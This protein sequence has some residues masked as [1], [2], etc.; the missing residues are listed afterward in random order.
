MDTPPR[1]H[2]RLKKTEGARL[3]FKMPHV[4]KQQQK[5]SGILL[6]QDRHAGMTERETGM[7]HKKDSGQAGMTEVACFLGIAPSGKSQ[8]CDEGRG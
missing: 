7:T 4:R 2:T 6:K 1:R 8:W 3:K 5:D